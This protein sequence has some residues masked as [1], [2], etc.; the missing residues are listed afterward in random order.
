MF[1]KKLYINKVTNIQILDLF[2][3][4]QNYPNYGRG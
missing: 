3:K 4:E 2:N 1:Q